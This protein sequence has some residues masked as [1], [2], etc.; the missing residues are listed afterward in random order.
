MIGLEALAGLMAEDIQAHARC[1]EDDRLQL[2]LDWLAA[3]T[4]ILQKERVRLGEAGGEFKSVLKT[5]L[6]SLPVQGALWEY[7]LI[8]DEVDWLRELDAQRLML[9]LKSGKGR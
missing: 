2:F 9:I 5:W 1:L 7:R 3:H 8:L 4:G 6:A